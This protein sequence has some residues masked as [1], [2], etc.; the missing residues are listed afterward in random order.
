MSQSRAKQCCYE[1]VLTIRRTTCF[2]LYFVKKNRKT[3][4]LENELS[5]L[6]ICFCF[7]ICGCSV[8]CKCNFSKHNYRTFWIY[9]TF[10]FSM[11]RNLHEIQEPRNAPA[12][13]AVCIWNYGNVKINPIKRGNDTIPSHFVILTDTAVYRVQIH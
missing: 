3:T 9:S 4:I 11:F 7:T 5:S 12:W 2:L 1:Q 6:I 8:S 10:Y 13:I